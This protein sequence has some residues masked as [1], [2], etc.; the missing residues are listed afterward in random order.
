VEPP[1][2]DVRD[3]QTSGIGAEIDRRDAQVERLRAVGGRALPL[4]LF[5]RIRLVVCDPLADHFLRPL[6]LG[7]LLRSSRG[8]K[9]QLCEP[10]YNPPAT[11]G[12]AVR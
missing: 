12:G 5:A 7:P 8:R 2:L 9:W 11:R 1:V 3:E 6:A 4:F 10:R